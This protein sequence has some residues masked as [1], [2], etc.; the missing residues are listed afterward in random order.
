VREAPLKV[1]WLAW[2][3]TGALRKHYEIV[4][5]LKSLPTFFDQYF[6][7]VIV[8]N[9]TRRQHH[10]SHQSVPEELRLNHALRIRQQR[11]EQH[12]V[13]ERRMISYDEFAPA[14]G[15]LT[16]ANHFKFQNA[17][18]PEH[19]D[20]DTEALPNDVLRP[21][22]SCVL[23]VNEQRRHR[24]DARRKYEATDTERC[25]RE[26]CPDQTPYVEH[27]VKHNAAIAI[28]SDRQWIFFR[29]RLIA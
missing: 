22:I 18:H 8:S 26:R 23:V 19:R 5:G 7:F 15:E 11:H 13:D 14:A 4:T 21:A 16:R 10:R 9:V 20:V 25:E 2:T 29:A 17:E 1:E 24:D 28:R 27:P 3:R 12:N 6:R